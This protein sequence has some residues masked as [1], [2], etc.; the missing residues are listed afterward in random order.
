MEQALLELRGRPI[1]TMDPNFRRLNE[2]YE[3][4]KRDIAS[5]EE[6][7]EMD[8]VELTTVLQQI[9]EIEKTEETENRKRKRHLNK[10][11]DKKI[12]IESDIKTTEEYLEI[13][14]KNKKVLE[15]QLSL[16]IVK[17]AMD[18]TVSTSPLA[19]LSAHGPHFRRNFQ[20]LI[21][22]YTGPGGTRKVRKSKKSRKSRK[23]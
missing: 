16:S 12:K 1:N 21:S 17:N 15:P 18:P 23:A 2:E 8:K 3:A 13:L 20:N 10:L 11:E 22:Q 9:E 6:E 14:Y 4:I 7:L 19:R 5:N